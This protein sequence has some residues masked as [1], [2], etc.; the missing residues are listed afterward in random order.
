M[1]NLVLFWQGQLPEYLAF[2]SQAGLATLTN[3]K[4]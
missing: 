3:Q 4:P 2:I 1:V